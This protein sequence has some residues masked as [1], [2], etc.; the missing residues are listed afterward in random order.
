MFVQY[1]KHTHVQ[2][3]V[4]DLCEKWECL[5]PTMPDGLAGT[6]GRLVG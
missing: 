2:P 5:A 1:P 3:S 6:L 4:R